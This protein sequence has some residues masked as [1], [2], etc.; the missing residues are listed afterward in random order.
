VRRQRHDNI[1]IAIPA[2]VDALP[3]FSRQTQPLAVLG[4]LR[5]LH[6]EGFQDTMQEPVF[7]AFSPLGVQNLSI[8]NMGNH[9]SFRTNLSVNC[10]TTQAS[11]R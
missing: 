8:L 1:K 10:L 3:T 9:R 2:A 5:N 7:V 4:T 11:N 6:P